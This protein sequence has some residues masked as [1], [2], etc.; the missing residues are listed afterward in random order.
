MTKPTEKYVHVWFSGA[1][2]TR[3]IRADGCF[4]GPNGELKLYIEHS[5]E[6][7]IAAG[8]WVFVALNHD[9]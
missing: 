6:L 7:I 9:S 2:E 4:V 5:I 3:P 1:S 8:Q